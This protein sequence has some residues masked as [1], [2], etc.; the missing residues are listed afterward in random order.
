MT[1]PLRIKI[2]ATLFAQ[3]MDRASLEADT[4]ANELGVSLDVGREILRRLVAAMFSDDGS[5]L[6]LERPTRSELSPLL[7]P[8]MCPGCEGDP[9]VGGPRSLPWHPRP[10]RIADHA[11]HLSGYFTAY[12]RDR[13]SD[14][15]LTKLC[16]KEARAR[17]WRRVAAARLRGIVALKGHIRDLGQRYDD[18]REL[19]KEGWSYADDYYQHKW[20]PP[21]VLARWFPENRYIQESADE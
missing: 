13:S 20:L 14:E 5:V 8:A 21:D 10:R 15:V 11:E 3:A 18:M 17:E 7:T 16:F 6:H 9:H 19:A 4:S 1:P 12:M 2:D